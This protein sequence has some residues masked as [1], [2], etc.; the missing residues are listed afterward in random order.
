MHSLLHIR[1]CTESRS[2]AWGQDRVPPSSPGATHSESQNPAS[3]QGHPWHKERDDVAF[4]TKLLCT[5]PGA[6]GLPWQI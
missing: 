4:V 1:S 2:P 5:R 3:V 6:H